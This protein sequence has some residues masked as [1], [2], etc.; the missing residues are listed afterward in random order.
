MAIQPGEVKGLLDSFEWSADPSVDDDEWSEAFS[1][2]L[3][4]SC[5]AT[6]YDGMPDIGDLTIRVVT[7]LKDEYV[8][9]HHAVFAR[10][11]GLAQ[12][13]YQR[14]LVELDVHAGPIGF[15]QHGLINYEDSN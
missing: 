13:I 2:A 10:I 15:N 3:G 5:E 9:K 1:D 4:H 8:T 7:G 11:A 6:T 12:E 14:K